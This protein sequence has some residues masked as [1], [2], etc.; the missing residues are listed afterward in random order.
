M[1]IE[2]TEA[3]IERAVKVMESR[4]WRVLRL[5]IDVVLLVL[6][7]VAP[8]DV[9]GGAAGKSVLFALVAASAAADVYTYR[10]V[11]FGRT[12]QE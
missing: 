12:S 11:L 6:I 2:R 4:S 1:T 7:I 8:S 3:R 5:A 10:R 9:W